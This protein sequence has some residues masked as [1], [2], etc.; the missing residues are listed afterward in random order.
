MNIP[1]INVP[2]SKIIKIIMEANQIANQYFKQQNEISFKTD[3]SPVTIADKKVSQFI[4]RELSILTPN[5]SII[6]EE[7]KE[8]PYLQRKNL[9]TCW[10][11]DP[12]D[13]TK[14][15]ISGRPEFTINLGLIYQQ[16]S[17]FGIVSCPPQKTIYFA[18][19]NKGAYKLNDNTSEPIQLKIPKSIDKLKII[20][21]RSHMTPETQYY[22]KKWKNYQLISK[23]S[24]LKFMAIAEGIAHI[25]PRFTG[26]MEW[27]TCASHIIVEE[28]GGII[29]HTNSNQTLLYNKKNLL[30][31]FFIVRNPHIDKHP[32]LNNQ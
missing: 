26:S 32:T 30:N 25:Y 8:I 21:S 12:I 1:I 2:S 5:I 17:I 22:L 15:F 29:T 28:A 6:D 19:K 14:E 16:K 7:S 10:C 24:S 23:G 4:T 9:Q 20:C 3:N 13:G 18:I 27:D 31:P 11:L